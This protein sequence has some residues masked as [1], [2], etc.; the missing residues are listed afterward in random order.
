[1]PI[2]F[3]K[4]VR[5][6]SRLREIALNGP[7]TTTCYRRNRLLEKR[8]TLYQLLNDQL[9]A[10]EIHVSGT[11][12][13]RVTKVDNDVYLNRSMESTALLKFLHQKLQTERD[14]VIQTSP[15]CTLGEMLGR[16]GIN[17]MT[18]SLSALGTQA[19]GDTFRRADVWSEKSQLFGDKGLKKPILGIHND[20]GGRYLA[21]LLHVSSFRREVV[22]PGHPIKTEMRVGFHDPGTLEQTAIWA[23]RNGFIGVP[24]NRFLIQFSRDYPRQLKLERVTSFA[25]YL[26]MLFRPLFEVT[27][28]PSICPALDALLADTT[29][30]DVVGDES[31]PTSAISETM[32][33]PELWTSPEQPPFVY[34]AYYFYANIQS[35]NNFR[36]LVGKSLLQRRL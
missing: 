1:M 26:E 32:P 18:I 8:F 16:I 25:G 36:L 10:K 29:G 22:S 31:E 2:S 34:Y 28:D 5:D 35:L 13:Y 9:E 20:L 4:F 11:D 21:E 12:M 7:A 3:G 30:F 15:R 6:C 33:P 14:T 24:T 19:D 23:K 27:K 17:E